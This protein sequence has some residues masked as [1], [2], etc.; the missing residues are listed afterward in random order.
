LLGLDGFRVLEV[1]ESPEE[2]VIRVETTAVVVG[3]SGCGGRAVAHDRMAVEVRDLPCFGRPARLVWN[4]RR[5][6]CV[7]VDCETKTWTETAAGLSS[8]ALLTEQ[9]GR[10]VTRQV[11]ENARPVAQLAEELAVCWWTVMAAVIEYGTP[12]V[13]DPARVGPT[14][15]LGV[16]ET[17][18]L[19]ATP[20]HPTLYATGLVDLDARIVIDLVAGN[21]A[22]TL[23]NWLGWQDPEW[24]AGIGTVTTDLAESYR[25]GLSPHLDHAV[26]V[27]DPFHVVR[28]AN[29]ASTRSGAASSRTPWGIGAANVTRYTGSASCSS[30]ATNASTT[31]HGTGC[32]LACASATPTTRCSAHGSP[33]SPPARCI[34]P[35]T[36]ATP[37]S[38]STK[39]S[40]AAFKTRSPRS[41]R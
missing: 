35:T 12:L 27:A 3:C 20:S 41:T 16:D 5:W 17:A 1:T 24:L 25:A 15:K 33:K 34:S 22:K 32:C 18:W 19:S 30:P 4:K 39:R 10:E 2:L 13:E 38:C 40:E 29:R 6:R 7:E 14:D 11:G 9:A 28:V 36:P 23:R 26:R 21:D 8:R 31:G 37:P